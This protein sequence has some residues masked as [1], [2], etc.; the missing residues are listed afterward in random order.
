[1]QEMRKHGVRKREC[2][3]NASTKKAGRSQVIAKQLRKE[4]EKDDKKAE[5]YNEIAGYLEKAK[6]DCEEERIKK[7][8]EGRRNEI[9]G[10]LSQKEAEKE[11]A[12]S[13]MR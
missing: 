6:D 3:T 8:D 1:M 11:G 12:K 5:M 10:M 7:L 13:R 2:V 4:A 9:R